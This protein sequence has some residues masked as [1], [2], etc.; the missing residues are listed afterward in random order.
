MIL[1]IYYL[2]DLICFL[3]EETE[4]FNREEYRR[5]KSTQGFCSFSKPRGYLSREIF[6]SVVYGI[7]RY[8]VRATVLI[9]RRYTR[10]Y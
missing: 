3:I 9:Y 6:W 8:C 7:V 2:A 1:H 4:F 10:L 5:G